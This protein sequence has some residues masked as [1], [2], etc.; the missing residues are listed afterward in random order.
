[1]RTL[2]ISDLHL[3]FWAEEKRDPFEE[4]ASELKAL[5]LIILAGDVSN[6][7]K[8]NWAPSLQRVAEY[9]PSAL[10]YVVPGNHDFYNFRFD[11]EDRLAEIAASNGALLAQMR[12]IEVG[13]VRFLCTTLWTDMELGL[14]YKV[15]SREAAGRMNDYRLIRAAEKGFKRL[16]PENTV[17]RHRDH[18]V[19]LEQELANPFAGKTVVVT[20]HAPHPKIFRPAGVKGLE[21]VY[22]SD[23]AEQI[24]R[25]QPDLWCYGHYHQG[26]D[27]KVG[28]TQI[29]NVSLGYPEE[30]TK[31]AERILRAIF[32]F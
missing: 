16:R 5:D 1:M 12:K 19:W 14:G 31:P 20:H 21:A 17:S 24:G 9:A 18:L 2:I 13:A 11:G 25:F 30:I 3:D 23:L 6:K 8:V 27:L 22:A 29:M 26:R 15:N 4:V 28:N 7:P 10:I 32:D